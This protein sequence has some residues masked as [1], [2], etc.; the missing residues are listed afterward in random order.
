MKKNNSP[1]LE[2]VCFF[3]DEL[4]EGKHWF[5][6]RKAHFGLIKE[7]V[8]K[9]CEYNMN[10]QHFSFHHIIPKLRL[11]M[12]MNCYLETSMLE[13]LRDVQLRSTT[14]NVYDLKKVFQIQLDDWA[15]RIILKALRFNC[16]EFDANLLQM[17][18]SSEQLN[19][20]P[21]YV[22]STCEDIF[23]QHIQN[24]EL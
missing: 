23:A 12:V 17:Y 15:E 2:H 14:G 20:T 3:Y 1:R 21:S 22:P 9:Y 5:Y 7:S 8:M 11:V 13:T 6:L 24:I 10:V 16:K 4:Q 19:S 18:S